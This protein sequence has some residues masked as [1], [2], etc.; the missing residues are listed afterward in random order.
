M[1]IWINQFMQWDRP[2]GQM[3]INMKPQ[4]LKEYYAARG[5]E[6]PSLA[7]RGY[8]WTKYNFIDKYTGTAIQ[9][10][11]LLEKL[12]AITDVPVG[13]T[14]ATPIVNPVFV[15]LNEYKIAEIVGAG[16]NPR[17]LEYFAR[18]G[19]GW[20]KDDETAWC[21]AFTGYCLEVAGIKS[22][23]LL[24]A[25]SYLKFGKETKSPKVGDIVVLWRG[26]IDAAEGHVGF[27]VTKRGG[28]VYMLGGNQGNEV[29]I[30]AFPESRVLSYRT[31]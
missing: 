9:N 25:R 12:L 18:T 16:T 26:S 8:L 27:F 20:V 11:K 2:C 24:N 30:S 15:A 7:D 31:Y 3:M 28:N 1:W 4:N 19:N 22:T 14:P 10:G 21:A 23:H 13:T 6:I 5:Q 17:V 29:N